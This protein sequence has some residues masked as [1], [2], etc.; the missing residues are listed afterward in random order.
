MGSACGSGRWIRGSLLMRVVRLKYGKPDCE[1][2]C[3]TPCTIKASFV[4][5]EKELAHCSPYKRLNFSSRP[6]SPY[7]FSGSQKLLTRL[8]YPLLRPLFPFLYSFFYITV[9]LCFWCCRPSVDRIIS[10]L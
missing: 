7:F 4:D 2:E 6:N 5:F 3:H 9:V 1:P 8:S 10:V